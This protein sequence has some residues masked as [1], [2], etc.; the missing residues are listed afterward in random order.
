M[1]DESES[2]SSRGYQKIEKSK[3]N[4][5][6]LQIFSF[7]RITTKVEGARQRLWVDYSELV[8]FFE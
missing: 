1:R 3:K 8:D 2:E 6:T 7:R 4:P 5:A